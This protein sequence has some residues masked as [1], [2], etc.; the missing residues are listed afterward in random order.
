MLMKDVGIKIHPLLPNSHETPYVKR[1]EREDYG[2]Y[3]ERNG[4]GRK[5]EGV[6]QAMTSLQGL[7]FC[8]PRS[9]VPE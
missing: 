3:V 6:R 4:G 2:A 8:P 9:T 1:E 5:G 7:F